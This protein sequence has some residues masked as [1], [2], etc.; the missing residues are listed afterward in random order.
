MRAR[1]RADGRARLR[2]DRDTGARPGVDRHRLH[3]QD[4]RSI[5]AG[6]DAVARPGRFHRHLERRPRQAGTRRGPADAGAVGGARHRRNACLRHP[7]F[8]VP[9]VL[10]AAD[11]RRHRRLGRSASARR[12]EGGA[13]RHHDRPGGRQPLREQRAEHGGAG[14][15]V[16]ATSGAAQRQGAPGHLSHEHRG[17]RPRIGADRHRRDARLLPHRR[18][19]TRLPRRRQHRLRP[20]FPRPRQGAATRGRSPSSR[21]R[22][23]WSTSSC[24]ASS[25]S[26]AT[27]GR[28]APIS[29]VTRRGSSSTASR[30][31]ERRMRGPRP[32]TEGRLLNGR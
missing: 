13:A 1:D 27:C 4:A 23:R 10:R 19:G 16:R 6:H 30:R 2:P 3:A 11:R 18:I 20:C 15:R 31:P 7:V 26:G 8:R 14:G 28:T 29:R 9:E 5:Q 17:G 12:R 21:S 24:Q 22:R 25:E 32:R